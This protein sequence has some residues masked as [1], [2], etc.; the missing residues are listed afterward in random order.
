LAIQKVNRYQAGN[1]S[2]LAVN[3]EGVGESMRVELNVK[4]EYS[5]TTYSSVMEQLTRR[6]TWLQNIQ[7]CERRIF[8]ANKL[9]ASCL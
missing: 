4:C 9:L 3:T 1:Y 2:C 5:L 7:V 8:S 6:M